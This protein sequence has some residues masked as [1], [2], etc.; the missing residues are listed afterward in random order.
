MSKLSWRAGNM[1]YPVPS[2]MVSCMDSDGK[3][4]IITIAWAGTVCSDPAMVSISVRK[5]RYS[6]KLISESKEFVINLVSKKLARA[7]DYCGVKSGRDIDKFKEMKLNQYVSEYMDTPA[8]EES[9]VNI[10]CK[11]VKVLELGSHDMFIGEVIGVTVDDKYMDDNNKF[12]LDKTNLIT[13][14]HGEYFTLGEKLG[15]FGYSVKKKGKKTR[16]DKILKKRSSIKK[17]SDN[18]KLK[19]K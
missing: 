8:I 15:T 5:S 11:V 3:A 1:L 9:P 17:S 6:H 16:Q 4:N 18:K 12:N 19:N 14:S 13:Y 10:Y 2:V 7:C